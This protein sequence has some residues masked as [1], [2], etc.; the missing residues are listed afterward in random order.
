MGI[1][2]SS[3]GSMVCADA[4]VEVTKDNRLLCLRHRRQEC[5]QV[6]VEFVHRLFMAGYQRD[7]DADDGGEFATSAELSRPSLSELVAEH[8]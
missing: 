2:H 1:Q 7:V 6:I 3:P 8:I 4:D 5:V